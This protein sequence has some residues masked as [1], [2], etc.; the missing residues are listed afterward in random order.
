MVDVVLFFDSLASR[1]LDFDLSQSAVVIRILYLYILSKA[2]Q[3]V[4]GLELFGFF[5][6]EREQ[7]ILSNNRIRNV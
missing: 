6:N 2:H 1:M 4:D 3:E 7:H 5:S